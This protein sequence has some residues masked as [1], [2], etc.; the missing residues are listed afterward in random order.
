MRDMEN[1]EQMRNFMI[2][3]Y[4]KQLDK[5]EKK[6]RKIHKILWWYF[7]KTSTQTIR[8]AN[9]AF[10]GRYEVPITDKEMENKLSVS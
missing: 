2:L 1:R 6:F 3:G 8:Y 4:D 10:M 7:K 5:C 9:S